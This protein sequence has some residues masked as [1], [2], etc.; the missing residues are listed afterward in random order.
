MMLE[1]NGSGT[2]SWVGPWSTTGNSGTTPGTNFLGTADSVDF[3]IKTNNTEKMRIRAKNGNVG[4]GVT[5]PNS[6]L[7][8]GANYSGQIYPEVYGYSSSTSNSA[9]GIRG[10]VATPTSGSNHAYGIFGNITC[11]IGKSI[12]VYGVS[13]QTSAGS[14]GRSYGAYGQAYNASAGFNYGVYGILTGSRTGAAVY[15]VDGTGGK[16]DDSIVGK[17]AGFFYGRTYMDSLIIDTIAALSHVILYVKGQMR[18]TD[19]GPL[20]PTTGAW[21]GFSDQRLKRNIMNF[22]GGLT[23]IRKVTP[24]RYRYNG[25]GGLQSD[26][27]HI[28]I[29]AQQMQKIMPYCIVPLKIGMSKKDVSKFQGNV[30]KAGDDMYTANVL[31]FKYDGL[32][33][34]MITAI[35]ELAAKS[36]DL[37]TEL[38]KKKAELD[39]L[40]KN[41]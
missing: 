14:G 39:A 4:I 7:S 24:V 36:D 19:D 31:G 20:K 12:G 23:I 10:Q 11:G 8:V 29:I 26:S 28:G 2:L 6:V 18:T 30:T 37:Q 35:K 16:S 15:G 41:R 21:T 9:T 38:D 32:V 40:E 1:N 17:W 13:Y 33:Y 27:L 25:M 5:A 22:S 34:C 3:V